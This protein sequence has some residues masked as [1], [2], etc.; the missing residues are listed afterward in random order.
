MFAQCIDGNHDKCQRYLNGRYHVECDCPCHKGHVIP[1]NPCKRCHG[2]GRH[3]PISVNNG[4]CF[5]CN[6]TGVEPK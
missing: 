1:D 6:G 2:T 5:R 4:I 3:G